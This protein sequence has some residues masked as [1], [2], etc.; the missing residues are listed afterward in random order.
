MKLRPSTVFR[1]CSVAFWVFAVVAVYGETANLNKAASSALV[2]ALFWWLGH[3]SNRG[4]D[5]K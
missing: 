2:F 4:G 3:E 1:V 5:K